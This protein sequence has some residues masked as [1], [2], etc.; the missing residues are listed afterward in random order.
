MMYTRWGLINALQSKLLTQEE[1]EEDE[2]EL[3]KQVHE[4]KDP[5]AAMKWLYEKTRAKFLKQ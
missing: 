1:K 5:V 2:F 3:K 4:A